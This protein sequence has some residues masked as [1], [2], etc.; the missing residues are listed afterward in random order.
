MTE[1]GPRKILKV[2]WS[3]A[4]MSPAS[5]KSGDTDSVARLLTIAEQFSYIKF[6]PTATAMSTIPPLSLCVTRW[7]PQW[8]VCNRR[9]LGMPI[10]VDLWSTC[11]LCIWKKGARTYGFVCN[12][13]SILFHTI[14]CS[15]VHS[16]LFSRTHAVHKPSASQS[17]SLICSSVSRGL[18]TPL[19]DMAGWIT[20][21]IHLSANTS[22]HAIW[23]VAG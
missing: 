22:V 20:S 17:I 12:H 8:H 11:L 2:F 23:G 16:S 18:Q 10:V 21:D 13:K 3:H 4:D 6:T 5:S 15:C 14:S 7:D 1:E 19:L 9:L